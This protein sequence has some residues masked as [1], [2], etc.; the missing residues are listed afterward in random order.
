MDYIVI[1]TM[2]SIHKD[3][4]ECRQKAEWNQKTRQAERAV[5][6]PN[7]MRI[8]IEIYILFAHHIMARLGRR[9]ST[10]LSRRRDFAQFIC[11]PSLHYSCTLISIPHLF[12][13]FIPPFFLLWRVARHSMTECKIFEILNEWNPKRLRTDVQCA[14]M[15]VEIQL[16]FF[17]GGKRDR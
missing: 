5:L 8:S 14:R 15:L 13:L 7:D 10:S 17:E 9:L 3:T 12:G 4:Y 11:S 16:G 2:C 1:S 6:S